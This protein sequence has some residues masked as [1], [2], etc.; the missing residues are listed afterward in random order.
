MLPEV[1]VL[2]EALGGTKTPKDSFY[3]TL[4]ADLTREKAMQIVKDLGCEDQMNEELTWYNTDGYRD[5]ENGTCLYVLADWCG[6]EVE[7]VVSLDDCM[8]DFV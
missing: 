1:N 8:F 7:V 6:E 2:F 3:G 4:P 5:D